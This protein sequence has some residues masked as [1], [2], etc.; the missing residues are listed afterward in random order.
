M[1][2]ARIYCLVLLTVLSVGPNLALCEEDNSFEAFQ[3][4]ERVRERCERNPNL[5]RCEK[6]LDAEYRR[7]SDLERDSDENA[8]LEEE[9]SEES[10]EKSVQKE[11]MAFCREEP[12]APRCAKLKNS[13]PRL[14]HSSATVTW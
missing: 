3:R 7:Y 11:L 10:R 2:R 4:K 12:D 8:M 9:R 6:F 5:S 14:R 1:E 13:R